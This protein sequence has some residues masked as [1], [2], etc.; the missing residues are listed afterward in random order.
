VNKVRNK[1]VLLPQPISIEAIELL[2]R[3]GFEIIEAESKDIKTVKELIKNVDAVIL[4]TGIEMD[5]NLLSNA[6]SLVTISRT[7]AGL[8][9]IDIRKATEKE[10]IVTSSIGAN[11]TSVAEHA[12]ALILGFNKAIIKLDKA[13]RSNNFSERY[14]YYPEDV[15]NKSLGIVGFGKIG[16]KVVEYFTPFTQSEIYVYDPIISESNRQKYKEKVTFLSKD[17]LFK[18]ADIVSLHVPLNSH[19]KHL[20]SLKELKSMKNSAIIINTSR[21]GVINEK[22]LIE[23]LKKNMI[24]GAALDVF[25]EEPPDKDNLLLKMDNVILTPHSAALTKECSVRMATKAAERVID[26]FNNKKPDH[27]ANPEVLKSKKWENLI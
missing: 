18:K 8:D 22:D 19:T 23:A 4:R 21:G 12:L 15:L 3:E 17:E 26:L 6:D 2:K 7:G 5:S 14:K 10:I 25:S 1:S 27:I 20:V 9:N 13:V 16:K 24:R 11:T